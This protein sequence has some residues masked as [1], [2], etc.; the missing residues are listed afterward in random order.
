[1]KARWL[2]ISIILLLIASALSARSIDKYALSFHDT[3]AESLAIWD[4]KAIGFDYTG[5]G[6][7][8]RNRHAEGFML[9]FGVQAPRTTINSLLTTNGL[10]YA[11]EN[12]KKQDSTE[13]QRDWTFHHRFKFVSL[14]GPALSYPISDEVS[15]YTGLGP[16]FSIDLFSNGNLSEKTSTRYS[17]V[18]VALDF[19][20]GFSFHLPNRLSA[21]V[22]LYGMYDLF[23]YVST[24]VERDGK[25]DRTY[26][27][28]S[29]NDRIY[30]LKAYGYIVMSHSFDFRGGK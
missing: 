15:V 14:L 28:F 8:R 12:R 13:D 4:E 5:F 26:T 19:E 24:E 25:R 29:F 3:V 1:M 2:R 30:H 21:Q 27:D 10:T 9:R 6:W 22:G 16:R 11:M 17:Y 7:I 23:S 20:A 18:Q